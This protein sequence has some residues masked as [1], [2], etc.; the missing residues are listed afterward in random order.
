MRSADETG[1]RSGS[2]TIRSTVNSA[3]MDTG[4]RREG[5]DQRDTEM[6][7][8]SPAGG[9]NAHVFKHRKQVARKADGGTMVIE[10]G[11]SGTGAKQ[12]LD[13]SKGFLERHRSDGN[14]E[15]M[16]NCFD[17]HRNKDVLETFELG[18][19]HLL[20]IPPQVSKLVSP[21]DNSFFGS[22]KARI[23]RMRTET[24]ADKEAA[25]QTL[26]A[27]YPRELVQHYFHHRGWEF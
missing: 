15:L 14:S 20:L 21:C 17:A 18:G 27:E 8:L 3:A 22:M 7:A 1:M 9:I 6:A 2:V 10:K 5:N 4:G 23:R 25:F 13:W 16:L 24:I 11:I 26:C 19:V 12:I